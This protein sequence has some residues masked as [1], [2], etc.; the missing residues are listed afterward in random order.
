MSYLNVHGRIIS[1]IRY[2]NTFMRF[3]HDVYNL[4]KWIDKISQVRKINLHF[5][6]YYIHD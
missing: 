6:V 1:T 5:H 2:D 3:L 4:F